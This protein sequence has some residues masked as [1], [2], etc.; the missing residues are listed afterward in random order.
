M[1]NIYFVKKIGVGDASEKRCIVDYYPN[2]AQFLNFLVRQVNQNT[3]EEAIM[4]SLYPWF[5]GKEWDDAF[6]YNES[7]KPGPY[8]YQKLR[9]MNP[10]FKNDY[11][12]RDRHKEITEELKRRKLLTQITESLQNK[13]REAINKNCPI[14]GNLET[15]YVHDILQNMT[16]EWANQESYEHM[17]KFVKRRVHDYGKNVD[18]LD[19][20]IQSYDQA[21]KRNIIIQHLFEDTSIDWFLADASQAKVARQTQVTSFFERQKKEK[22]K[23]MFDLAQAYIAT[24]KEPKLLQ[25]AM[26][27]F[28]Q[29]Q[30]KR[31]ID[32]TI[33]DKAVKELLEK[34]D[35]ETVSLEQMEDI[36]YSLLPRE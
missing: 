2:F 22:I 16:I 18:S 11:K 27:N 31:R 28:Y 5:Y 10:E 32:K 36:I 25:N 13:I 21:N 24:H 35:Q 19:F 8:E 4:K 23:Y 14:T 7:N 3:T 30:Y 15:V 33:T 29:T 9:A 6:E 34:M 17:S 1:Q 12:Q 20:L 26:H